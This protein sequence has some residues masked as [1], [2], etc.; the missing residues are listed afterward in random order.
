MSYVPGEDHCSRAGGVQGTRDSTS[1]FGYWCRYTILV[2]SHPC[3]HLPVPTGIGRDMDEMKQEFSFGHKDFVKFVFQWLQGVP[4]IEVTGAKIP[5]KSRVACKVEGLEV[6]VLLALLMDILS[7]QDM[8]ML[9]PGVWVKTYSGNLVKAQWVAMQ[10]EVVRNAARLMKQW[11][12]SVCHQQAT[13]PLQQTE[14]CHELEENDVDINTHALTVA[15]A[16]IH[17]SCPADF[18]LDLCIRMWRMLASLRMDLL[19]V[20]S[21]TT[22]LSLVL[23][24]G[25]R[26]DRELDLSL[27]FQGNPIYGLAIEDILQ[28]DRLYA[29]SQS[30]RFETVAAYAAIALSRLRSARKWSQMLEFCRS[31]DPTLNDV[32]ERYIPSMASHCSYFRQRLLEKQRCPSGHL[33]IPGTLNS[34]FLCDDC[35]LNINGLFMLGCRQCDF[36]LCQNCAKAV[37]D[38]RPFTFRFHATGHAGIRKQQR[39]SGATTFHIP[40]FH[41]TIDHCIILRGCTGGWYVY[42]CFYNSSISNFMMLD[43]MLVVKQMVSCMLGRIVWFEKVEATRNN[44]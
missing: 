32:I 43:G 20:V 17:Q 44:A 2:S 27:N 8:R 13:A 31:T 24:R 35:Q 28:P 33:L 41:C 38:N 4:G 39:L 10:P 6:D 5:H 22:D 42:C 11:A 25:P 1:W 12:R 3:L 26:F 19:V 30:L 40:W 21:F 29:C 7:E 14:E 34:E 37:F 16:A 15:I 36:D 9:E 18:A 23:S